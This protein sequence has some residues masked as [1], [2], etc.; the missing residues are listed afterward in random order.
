ADPH[1]HRA[2]EDGWHHG[3]EAPARR[4]RDRRHPDRRRDRLGHAER[5]R[6]CRVGR[7]QRVH[8]QADRGRIVRRDRGSPHRRE[9]RSVSAKPRILVVDDQPANVKLLE[10]LL[11]LSGYEVVTALS[12]E[13][14]LQKLVA[15]MPDLVLLDVVMPKMSGYQVCRAIR[16]N[17]ATQLLPVV[18]VT[19]LDPGEE[20]IKG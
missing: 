1:G 7:I 18:M 9:G 12:G 15:A 13:E 11:S 6:A 16:E 10:Q 3:A 8:R 19:A 5:A 20:R 14:A 2:A 17:E 4:S